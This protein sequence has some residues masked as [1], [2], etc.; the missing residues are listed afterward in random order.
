MSLLEARG[1]EAVFRT[2]V[3]EEKSEYTRPLVFWRECEDGLVKGFIVREL[4]GRVF[5]AEEVTNFVRYQESGE[6][7]SAA[8]F[9]KRRRRR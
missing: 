9:R 2:D 5:P 6:K 3:Q 4:T 8:P 7:P 1:W